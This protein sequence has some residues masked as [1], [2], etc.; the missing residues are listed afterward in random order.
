MIN[1]D[2]P[3]PQRHTPCKTKSSEKTQESHITGFFSNFIRYN[4]NEKI[5]YQRH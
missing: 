3:A 4:Y 2:F 1:L 5:F